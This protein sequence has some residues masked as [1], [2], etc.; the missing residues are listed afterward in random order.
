MQLVLQ[1]GARENWFES[2]LIVEATLVALGSLAAFVWWEL[3]VDEPVVQLR[4]LMNRQ[5]LGGTLLVFL[6]GIVVFGGPFLLP[7]FLQGLRGYP[8]LDTG[9]ILIPSYVAWLLVSPCAG[10]LYA[11]V[12][13]RL[14]LG[15]SLGCIIGG[16]YTMTGLSLDA[17]G[18]NLLPG[19]LLT[20]AGTALLNAV[21]PP[22]STATMPR[23]LVPMVTSLMQVMRRIGGNVGYA[24]IATLVLSRTAVHR[25]HLIEDVSLYHANAMATLEGTVG[26]LV[27]TGMPETVAQANALRL[28]S[29]T[30]Q[31]QATMLAFNDIFWI[32]A[33]LFVIGVPLLW[34]LGGRTRPLATPVPPASLEGAGMPR[35]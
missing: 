1:L 24:F 12:D 3:H 4:V 17:A 30:V 15:V 29:G 23:P 5:C 18:V 16:Y 35:P 33:M 11:C 8:A 28:L 7:L 20:G 2:A 21:A 31:K 27:G 6:A 19:L 32:M 26:R 25:A 22:A 9:I 34:L 10:R 14:L 13:S